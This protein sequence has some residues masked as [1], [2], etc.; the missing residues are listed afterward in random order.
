MAEMLCGYFKLLAGCK[1]VQVDRL[2][3]TSKLKWFGKVAAD[4]AEFVRDG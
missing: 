1:W 4:R 3:A 2:K